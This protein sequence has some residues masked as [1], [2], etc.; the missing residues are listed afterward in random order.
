M[1]NPSYKPRAKI[2]AVNTLKLDSIKTAMPVNIVSP[3]TCLRVFATPFPTK[4]FTVAVTPPE[5]RIKANSA[6]TNTEKSNTL[7]LPG[8]EAVPTTLSIALMGAR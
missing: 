4:K 5:S 6:P 8:L 2:P 1:P 7:V 3:P